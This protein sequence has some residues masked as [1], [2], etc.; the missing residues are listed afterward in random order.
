[1][2]TRRA[3]ALVALLALAPL[4]YRI[5]R[6]DGHRER[7]ADAYR[8]VHDTIVRTE[9]VVEQR[10]RVDTV[11]VR[12]ATAIADSARARFDSAAIAIALAADSLPALP[13]TLVLPAV[14]ACRSA[15][16]A[17]STLIAELRI[18]VDDALHYGALEQR[19]AELAEHEL[20]HRSRFGF[21][22]GAVLGAVVVS[23]FHFLLK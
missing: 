21:K 10:L 6:T 12:V 2:T 11:R 19:R 3:I 7:D 20:A 18:T 23:A 8:T 17:D 14:V 1:M 15:L 9:R 22:S 4:S 13:D 5:G 16:D